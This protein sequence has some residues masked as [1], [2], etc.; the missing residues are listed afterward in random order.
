MYPLKGTIKIGRYIMNERFK[1]LSHTIYECKYHFAICPKYRFRIFKGGI[2]EYTKQQTYILCRQK[3]LV[4][5]LELNVQLDHIHLVMCIPPEYSASYLAGTSRSVGRRW[6]LRPLPIRFC[7]IFPRLITIRWSGMHEGNCSG[8]GS[9]E[10]NRQ[11]RPGDVV[12]L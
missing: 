5:I 1:K 4:E 2:A 8:N 7:I 12:L 6:S 3:E 9:S 10:V 11:P